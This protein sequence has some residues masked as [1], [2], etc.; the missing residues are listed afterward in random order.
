MKCEII[1]N[2]QSA[3]IVVIYRSALP[4]NRKEKPT[5]QIAEIQ[6]FIVV[7]VVVSFSKCFHLIRIEFVSI[8]FFL[9]ASGVGWSDA[10]SKILI[11][12]DTG[13]LDRW[14]GGQRGQAIEQIG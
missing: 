9:H 4:Q 10:R 12:I 11:S 2:S 6:P 8:A 7:V 5:K 3:C 14:T 1:I 13:R